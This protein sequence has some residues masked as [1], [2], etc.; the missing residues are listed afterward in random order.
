VLRFATLATILS[1]VVAYLTCTHVRADF[2]ISSNN[3]IVRYNALGEVVY[4]T[5]FFTES[6]N[7]LEIGPEGLLYGVGNDLGFTSISRFN[8]ETGQD[9]EVFADFTPTSFDFLRW[10]KIDGY[11]A[12]R[13]LRR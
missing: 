8:A 3:E 12:G 9:R 13:F 7:G 6:V 2:I 5:S 4:S 11:R 10:P 1:V